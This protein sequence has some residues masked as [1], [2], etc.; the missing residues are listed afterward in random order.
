MWFK[1]KELEGKILKKAI[2]QYIRS[3]RRTLKIG[4]TL[5][6]LKQWI[7][8]KGLHLVTTTGRPK[9]I[10]TIL[11]AKTGTAFLR[12]ILILFLVSILLFS[13]EE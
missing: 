13:N 2:L 3:I 8:L 6:C 1:G 12:A 4:R 5:K 11:I 7:R 9:M 10:L